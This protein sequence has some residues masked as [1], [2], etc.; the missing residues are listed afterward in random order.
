[1]PKR[2]KV[3]SGTFVISVLIK[4]F[5]F[6]VVS[7]KGSHVKLRCVNTVTIVPLHKELAPGTLSGIL[8]LAKIEREDFLR[9]TEK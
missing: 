5:D 2:R 1:M 9:A 6:E 3:F 7:Q 4:S 8:R